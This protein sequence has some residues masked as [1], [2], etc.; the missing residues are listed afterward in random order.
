VSLAF[1]HTAQPN[2]ETFRLL[3]ETI[4]PCI[5]ATHA[6]LEGVLAGAVETGS[7]TERMRRETETAIGTLAADGATVIVCT[8]ST[9]G[10]VAEATTI[11]G[12]RVMRIDR[13][14]AE[15]A[16]ERGRR[17]LVAATLRST[18]PPTMAL[19]RQVAIEAHRQAD[20]AEL[21]CGDAWPHFERGD[22]VAYAQ[23]IADAVARV[24]RDTDIV[25]LA[26]AS[27]AGAAE[28]LR[29][30]G[31]EALASPELGVRAAIETIHRTTARPSAPAP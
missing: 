12:V 13:P 31:I 10:G 24:A 8:C 23:A 7:V 6:V 14:M 26:Q 9:I 28:F 25:V 16:V 19:I 27:M 22:R 3:V 20:T 2:V 5:V 11:P 30:R 18:L 4:D 21:L 29:Q 1:L 15:Q 17:I